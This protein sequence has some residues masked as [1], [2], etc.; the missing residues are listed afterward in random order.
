ML[1]GRQRGLTRI[2]REGCPDHPTYKG[3]GEVPTAH[4]GRCQTLH[5]AWTE[6]VEAMNELL[7][8]ALSAP[9]S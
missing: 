3:K 8:D 6:L 9:D 1:D 7:D 2:I 4:C 5:A